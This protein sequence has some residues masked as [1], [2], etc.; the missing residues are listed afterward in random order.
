MILIFGWRAWICSANQCARILLAVA[1]QDHARLDLADEVQQVVAVGVGG[2]I[3]VLH[4]AAAGDFAG[5]GAEEERLARL[6]GL[7]PATRRVGVGVAD[8]EDGLAF[9]ADHA[10]RQ[11]VGGGVL[12][13]H[14]GGDDEEAA[15]G[16]LH[17]LHLPLFQHD[18]VQGIAQLEV[19]ILPMGA[20]RFQVVDFRED[21]AQAADVNGLR[22]ELAFAASAWPAGRGF[23]GCG[24]GQRRG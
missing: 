21:A 19:G 23:P 11:V 10:Q 3:E 12:A 13:H 2:E 7:E 14:A 18:E 17:L 24:P 16:E 9:V 22:L 15:A 4:F 8:E 6:G 1:E 5:A 20:V